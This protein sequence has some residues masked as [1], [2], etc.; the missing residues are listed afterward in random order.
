MKSHVNYSGTSVNTCKPPFSISSTV[1][2]DCVGFWFIHTIV[3]ARN[4]NQAEEL[5]TVFSVVKV[6]INWLGR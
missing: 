5:D 3:F 4:V 6:R 1:I 2:L